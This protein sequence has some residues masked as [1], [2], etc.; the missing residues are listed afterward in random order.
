MSTKTTKIITIRY[1]LI[2]NPLPLCLDIMGR[3]LTELVRPALNADHLPLYQYLPKVIL[4]YWI[5]FVFRAQFD[6]VFMQ[7]KAFYGCLFIMDQRHHDFTILSVLARLANGQI[8]V[9]NIAPISFRVSS[10]AMTVGTRTGFLDLQ[11]L[12]SSGIS[13]SST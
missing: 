5:F 8:L 3:T 11:A 7:E 4:Q 12:I 10:R 13:T 2:A 9:Q 6:M 1:A